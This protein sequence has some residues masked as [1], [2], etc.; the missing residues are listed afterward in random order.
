MNATLTRQAAVDVGGTSAGAV[1]VA[2]GEA[3]PAKVTREVTAG[4]TVKWRCQL[5]AVTA[6]RNRTERAGTRTPDSALETG[7]DSLGLIC[8]SG[9]SQGMSDEEP[10][11]L[12]PSLVYVGAVIL[13]GIPATI[14]VLSGF[15]VLFEVLGWEAV[16]DSWAGGLLVVLVSL[17]V[18]LQLA[19]E[20]AAVQLGGIKALGRGSPRVALA[21]YVLVTACVFVALATATVIGV[22]TAVSGFGQAAIVLGLLVAAAG[23][24]AFYRASAAF[25]DGLRGTGA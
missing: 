6:R 21:R 18:G 9:E 7:N 17:L 12:V 23:V 24:V 4:T 8:E 13:F 10:S 3:V 11:L 16:V 19:V 25:V 22:S 20:A 15:G 14:V 1:L 5:A 2:D